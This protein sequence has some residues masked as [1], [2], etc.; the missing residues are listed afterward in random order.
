MTV[1]TKTLHAEQSE[2][3]EADAYERHAQASAEW[4][5]EVSEDLV[6]LPIFQLAQKSDGEKAKEGH[7][8]LP[9]FEPIRNPIIVP[10]RIGQ[11]RMWSEE[12]LDN[13]LIIHCSAPVGVPFGVQRTDHARHNI[14]PGIACQDCAFSQWGENNEPPPC[15]QQLQMQ[16]IIA[17]VMMPARMIFQRSGMPVARKMAGVLRARGMRKSAFR[18]GS[19]TVKQNGYTYIVPTFVTIIQPDE[20]ARQA[21][22]FASGQVALP[23]EHDSEVPF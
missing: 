22:E 7:Y 1:P 17:D 19:E 8:S 20:V 15:A 9:G 12:G 6:S 21:L 10:I 13:R 2:Q 4:S 5:D 11:S 14:P 23:M 16:V 3:P 18:L